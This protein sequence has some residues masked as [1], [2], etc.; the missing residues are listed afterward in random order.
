MKG[1]K[2]FDINIVGLSH[3]THDFEYD[4]DAAFFALFEHSLVETG[5][6][7]VALLLDKSETMLTL[8]FTIQGVV[9]LV[10]DKSLNTFDHNIDLTHRLVYKFGAEYDELDDDIII[11]PHNEYRINVAQPIYEYI[12]LAVPMRKIHPDLRETDQATDAEYALV[13]T[14]EAVDDAEADEEQEN[15]QD[16][17]VD[18]RWQALNQLKNKSS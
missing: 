4:I 3:N 14:S 8:N 10:C 17:P 18:P 2:I 13:Y 12:L 9:E 5:Q 15:G 11:I 16:Q 1:L 7:K 6:L